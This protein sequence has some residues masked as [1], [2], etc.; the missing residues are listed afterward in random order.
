MKMV[1]KNI[2]KLIVLNTA[3]ELEDATTLKKTHEAIQEGMELLQLVTTVRYLNPRVHVPKRH[4]FLVSLLLEYD[5]ICFRRLLRM[6]REQFI[7]IHDL[8]C[9]HPIF[10]STFG[11]Q[12]SV[13]V[14]LLCSLNR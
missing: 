11:N 3:M 5:E 14:Q 10:K 8:I 1:R 6:N 13:C 12:Y 2:N 9:N 4:D 7:R